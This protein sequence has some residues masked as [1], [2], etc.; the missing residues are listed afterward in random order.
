MHIGLLTSASTIPGTTEGPIE[1][2][3]GSVGFGVGA[4]V[5]SSVSVISDMRTSDALSTHLQY[6]QPASVS[7]EAVIA[8]VGS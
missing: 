4:K 6:I 1:D 7:Q 3:G 2:V 8:A 5:S